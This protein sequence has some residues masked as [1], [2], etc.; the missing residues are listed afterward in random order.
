VKAALQAQLE[1]PATPAP[2]PAP[3]PVVTNTPRPGDTPEQIAA[4]TAPRNVKPKPT[5]VQVGGN[6]YSTMPIQP[7]TYIQANELDFEEG[8]I[9][10]Y[11]SRWRNK[12]GI[13]DL[14]KARDMLDKKIAFE[15]AKATAGLMEYLRGLF[16]TV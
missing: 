7:L 10:K 15:E 1:Q 16:Q 8:N 13:E 6:H 12:N 3:A 9:I 11:V 14:K 2:G 4:R 5:E